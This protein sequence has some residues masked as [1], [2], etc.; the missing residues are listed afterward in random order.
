MVWTGRTNDNL[1]NSTQCTT[2][3]IRRKKKRRPTQTT[4]YR[5]C[6]RGH[7]ISLTDIEGSNRL[8]RGHSFVPITAKWLGSETGDHD[9]IRSCLNGLGPPLPGAATPR[10]QHYIR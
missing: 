5:Q 6:K 4:M 2:C 7:R 10:V 9:D 3:N 8:D 1:P